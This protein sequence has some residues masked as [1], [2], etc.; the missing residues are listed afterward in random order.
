MAAKKKS[1]FGLEIEDIDKSKHGVSQYG[2]T[3]KNR[4]SALTLLMSFSL[5]AA[6]LFTHGSFT[7]STNFVNKHHEGEDT[8]APSKL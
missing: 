4:L 8:K 2:G 7:R 5:P 3:A 6:N 1:Q